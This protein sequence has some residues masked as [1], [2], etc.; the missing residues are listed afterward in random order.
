MG[1][2]LYTEWYTNGDVEG[3]MTKRLPGTFNYTVLGMSCK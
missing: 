3:V 1:K 2:C